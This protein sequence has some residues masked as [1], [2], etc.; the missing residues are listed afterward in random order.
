[1]NLGEQ[2]SARALYRLEELAGLA[3]CS[4]FRGLRA[5]GHVMEPPPIQQ[6]PCDDWCGI[7]ALPARHPYPPLRVM[8]YCVT[9]KMINDI[10]QYGPHLCVK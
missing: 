1:M 2:A 6:A 4:L 5:A 9:A 7:P 10:I 8:V 3:G